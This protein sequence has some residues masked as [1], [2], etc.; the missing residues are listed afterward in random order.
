[1]TL[2]R[3]RGDRTRRRSSRTIAYA[4]PVYTTEGRR[5]QRRH[6]EI[7]GRRAHA[8]LRRVL[9]LGL[10]RGRR[11]RARSASPSALGG[12]AVSAPA[13]STRARSATAASPSASTSSATASRMAYVDLD[14]LP[15]LLGGRLVAPRG[16]GSCASAARDY[17]GDPAVPLADAVRALV[18]ERHGHAPRAARS[19]CSPTCARSGTASTR[20]ASTTASTGRRAPRGRR[21]RGHEHALGRAPRLR[22][23]GAAS[24]GAACSTA[25]STRRCTSRRSWAWTSATT[26]G[27]PRPGATLSVHIESQRARRAARSTRR[28]ALRRRPLDAAR[29]GAATARYPAAT[30]RMLALIY[31]HAAAL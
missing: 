3:T 16:P 11:R 22:A 26:G 23:R 9:G 30:L 19:A 18:A 10:P 27:R 17:L 15:G 14:E 4:H 12:A 8:L 6:D 28:S 21:R 7:S 2:N 20:S 29:A 1:M 25:A 5:A 31:A 13:R 24:D